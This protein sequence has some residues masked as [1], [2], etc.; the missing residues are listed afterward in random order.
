MS[1]PVGLPFAS[2]TGA[3]QLDVEPAWPAAEHS[4][5]VV[6]RHSWP[7]Q[8]P[9][10]SQAPEPVTPGTTVQQPLA[11]G[12]ALLDVQTCAHALLPVAG[13][14]TQMAPSTHG[15]TPHRAEPESAPVPPESTP[16]PL[17]PPLEDEPPSA[18]ASL[19]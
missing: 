14:V 15:L 17:S 16:A 11:V 4:A 7:V 13:S 9:A 6:Q 12:Q 5:P 1:G 19:V 8:L 10:G 3:Q 18:P 2:A